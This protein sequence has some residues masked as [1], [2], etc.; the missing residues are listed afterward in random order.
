MCVPIVGSLR[1]P[2]AIGIAMTVAVF[3]RLARDYGERLG[4]LR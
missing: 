2:I 3:V 1:I 4:S